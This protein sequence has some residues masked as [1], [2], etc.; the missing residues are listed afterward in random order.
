[1]GSEPLFHLRWHPF[2]SA[3][4]EDFSS[5]QYFILLATYCSFSVQ[6]KKFME[7]FQEQYPIEKGFYEYNTGNLREYCY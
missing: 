3:S 5:S 2:G 6:N 1:M 7:T 4:L